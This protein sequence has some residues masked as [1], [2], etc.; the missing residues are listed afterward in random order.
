MVYLAA[1]SSRAGS[2]PRW[3]PRHAENPRSRAPTPAAVAARPAPA[4]RSRRRRRPARPAAPD[5]TLERWWS[6]ETATGRRSSRQDMQRILACA[7]TLA[8][9]A[10]PAGAGPRPRTWNGGRTGRDAAGT[11]YSPLDQ[12][13]ADTIGDLQ[14]VWRQ[15]VLPEAMRGG[16]D[17]T[18][19][20]AA[21]NTPLMADGRLYISSA[22][23]TGRRSTPRPARC[24]GSTRRPTAAASV[25][26]GC[27]RPAASP[28]GRTRRAAT[29]GCSRWSAPIWWR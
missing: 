7:L 21:Q 29:P 6:A 11:K 17:F 13:N 27:A 5:T 20:V 28:T 12:I 25:H 19:P 14:I 26:A 18:P 8:A 9:I 16:G 15:S 10:A 24:S 3:N 2:T 22:L 4:G 1:L 23:G